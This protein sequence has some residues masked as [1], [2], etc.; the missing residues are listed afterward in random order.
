[1][2]RLLILGIV[3]AIAGLAGAAPATAGPP[4]APVAESLVPAWKRIS[5]GDPRALELRSQV[6]LVV[7]E[8]QGVILYARDPD[9]PRPIAS[10]TKL[11]TIMTLLDARLSLE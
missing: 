9:K 3:I 1:M 5:Y 2:A 8:R 10:L 6:G 11:L 7:D 4:E